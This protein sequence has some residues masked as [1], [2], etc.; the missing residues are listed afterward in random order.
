VSRPDADHV[1][2]TVTGAVAF[3]RAP[4]RGHD[5]PPVGGGPEPLDADTPTGAAAVF[6]TLLARSRTMRV[7]L[8][9][10]PPGA[11]D[12][13]WRTVAERRLPAVG[14]GDE[15]NFRVTW[16]GQLDVPADRPVPLELQTPGEQPAWR[17]LVEERELLDADPVGQPNS[18]GATS[19]S[20]R[21]VYADAIA[22]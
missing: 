15:T 12:L 11:G 13:E 3:L 2:V 21:V 9:V 14:V 19:I 22:L 7:A 20:E 4:R 17:V 16:S 1:R 5:D 8:Q 6:D 10:L 18:S